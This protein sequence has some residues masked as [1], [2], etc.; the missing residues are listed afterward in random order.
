MTY[1]RADF[2]AIASAARGVSQMQ[3]TDRGI[4]FSRLPAWTYSQHSHAPVVATMVERLSGAHLAFETSARQVTVT[5][6]SLRDE[7]LANGWVAGPTSIAL[8]SAGFE[9]TV[10]HAN[11]DVRIWN[12]DQI[13]E[14]RAGEDSVAVFDLPDN[15]DSRLIEIWLPQNCPIELISI[16]ADAPLSPADA[17]LP[18]WVHYGSSISHCEDA[19]GPLGVWP[20]AAARA[21]DLDIYNLGM[22]GCANLE[23][24]SART[25]RDLPADFISLKLGINVVNGANHTERTFGPAVHGFIDTIREGHPTTPILIISP[26]CCPA[27]ENNPGP[28]E[29]DE[30][31]MVQGQPHSRH[32]WI[33]ELTLVGIRRILSELVATRSVSDP[34]IF[35]MDG[36]QLFDEVEAQTMPDGIHP[37]AAGY[38]KIAANFVSRHPREWLAV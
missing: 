31:G 26:V 20:V 22:G 4:R 10:S 19:D 33:G 11:G 16:E 9:Q 8:T 32:G 37:D 12:G 27:H 30:F 25:I 18:Q 14:L 38:R 29:T 6:R 5:Y 7:N 35:Y 2:D 34:N 21:L 17:K 23:Q 1:H 36:L 15:Y 28:S 24:F 13:V 3:Q